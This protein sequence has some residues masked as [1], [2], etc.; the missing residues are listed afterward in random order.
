MTSLAP[1]MRQF[2]VKRW[3]CSAYLAGGRVV[4][5]AL[6]TLFVLHPHQVAPR[7]E[8]VGERA[9]HEQAMNVLVHFGV[10]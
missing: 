6:D 9:G 8:Q 1:Q 7:Q 3:R 5:R 4:F 10:Q 2:G